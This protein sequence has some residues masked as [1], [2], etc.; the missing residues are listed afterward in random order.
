MISLSEPKTAHFSIIKDRWILLNSGVKKW[1]I[2]AN[3]I[4]EVVVVSDT[5]RDRAQQTVVEGVPRIR[6]ERIY[7]FD[8]LKID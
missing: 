3:K 6:P 7:E 1:A 4:K 5:G 2:R 8:N